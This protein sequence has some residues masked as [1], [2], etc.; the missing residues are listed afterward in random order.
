MKTKENKRKKETKSFTT[1]PRKDP[2]ALSSSP[3][4]PQTRVRETPAHPPPISKNPSFK[5]PSLEAVP[6][7]QG[8]PLNPTRSIIPPASPSEQTP[9]DNGASV[10]WAYL[11]TNLNCNYSNDYVPSPSLSCCYCS[12]NIPSRRTQ[13]GNS[14]G[15]DAKIWIKSGL[16]SFKE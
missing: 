8:N 7:S 5:R 6:P 11:M 1:R 10:G 15:T 9:H 12:V 4:N 13:V 16:R 14:S 2:N 3:V